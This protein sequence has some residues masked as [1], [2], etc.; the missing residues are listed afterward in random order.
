MV[1][2]TC[3]KDVLHLHVDS[4]ISGR[5]EKAH[6]NA[7][8][9]CIKVANYK[10]KRQHLDEKSEWKSNF[11][12]LNSSLL[13]NWVDFCVSNW[14]RFG[15][16]IILLC[17][18][19]LSGYGVYKMKVGIT[20]EKLK[21]ADVYICQQPND[22]RKPE[23]IAAVMR[24]VA[25]FENSPGSVGL[26]STEM[27]LNQYLGYVG[28][29]TQGSV[30]FT[31]KYLPE[32]FDN[33]EFHRWS[34]YVNLGDTQDCLEDKPSCINKFFFSTGFQDATAWTARLTLLQNWRGIASASPVLNIT[35]YENFSMY[36]D[37]LLTIPPA[38]I[39]TVLLAL[40]C[41]SLVLVVFTPN[42]STIIPGIACILSINLGVFGLLYY[43]DIDLDPIT[44]TTTVSAV[45]KN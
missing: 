23:A 34:H 20:S 19:T 27:W 37:Q 43:W 28:T 12:Q 40:L 30:E 7:Y 21:R 4:T 44:I 15:F 35:I 18:W 10:L 9:P 2:N 31:Y 14:T 45:F 36:A 16:A 11:S 38:A 42:Y 32:F 25:K 39:Q 3:Y 6:L 29:Q 17:Y 22:L 41:M 8:V 24:V 13:D 5:R 33:N 26:S 1:F